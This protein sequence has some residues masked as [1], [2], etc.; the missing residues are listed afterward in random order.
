[1]CEKPRAV[2]RRRD[3]AAL[4]GK[5]DGAE[6]AALAG[7]Q[8]EIAGST[9]ISSRLSIRSPKCVSISASEMGAA[10]RMRALR[11][12]AAHVG[13]HKI[14][15]ARQRRSRD[16]PWRRVHSPAGKRRRCRGSWRCGPD[17]PARECVPA[18]RSLRSTPFSAPACCAHRCAIRRASSARRDRSRRNCRAGAS[19]QRHRRQAR[20]RPRARRFRPPSYP[21]PCARHRPPCAQ[22]AAAAA[23]PAVCGLLP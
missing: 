6:A 5:R 11:G 18:D 20:A 17:R 21:L 2:R 4:L 16:R 14:G 19:D 9:T 8:A 1:M 12:R 10:S 3:G 15:L 22:A 13:D 7:A 23:T